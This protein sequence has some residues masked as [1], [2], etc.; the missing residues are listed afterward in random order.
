MRRALLALLALT[1][2]AGLLAGGSSAAADAPRQWTSAFHGTDGVEYTATNHLTKAADGPGRKW[3]LVWAGPAKQPAPDFLAVIDATPGSPTYGKIANT[4]TMGPGTGNE[5]HH[6]QYVWHKGDRIY[7][8]GILS[9]TTFVF[10]SRALPALRL[11]GVNT[12]TQTPCGT[13]PDAYQVLGDGTAYGTYMGGPNV[14][15]PCTY[16]NGQVR[17][18]NGAAGSPGEIVHIGKDG[19]TLA[20]IPAATE[21]SEDARQC[22]DVPALPAAS[23]ANPHG[24]AVREDLDIMVSSDFAEA[25]NFMTPNSPLKENLARQTVRVF[26]IKDRNNPKLISVSKVHDGPRG[27]LEKRAFFRESRVVMEVATTN[28]R[29]HRGAF[30]SSMAGGAVFYTPDITAKKPTWREVFDDS[31]AYRTFHPGGSVN[32]GGDNSSWLAVSP[33]DRYLFHT[34]MGQSVPYGKPLDV[35]TGMLYVLDIHKLLAR[36]KSSRCSIDQLNEA[37]AGG[38]E[39]DCPELAGVVPIRDVT[40]GGPHWGSMDIFR[41]GR[42]GVY[43]ETDRI[44]R[45]AVANYFVA[46][47][48]GGDGDHRVCMFNLDGRGRPTLDRRF[49]DENTGEPCVAFNRASWPHGDYGN[50]QPHGVLF[51]VSDRALR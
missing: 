5:P 17:V 22:G 34:V 47:S 46:G 40:S 35:T 1:M 25:R 38:T 31:T 9:D 33:D 15:G 32:G 16:T 3:L 8:G 30:V 21:N 50:A 39:R 36:G 20:E 28:R 23:C 7:A 2:T 14:S 45:I 18:G 6:L 51:A 19:R 44:S 27:A 49:R 37:Y 48:F 13:L 26:D 4:V 11:V 42:G 24:I 29:G 10:D 43:H 41:R 12:P